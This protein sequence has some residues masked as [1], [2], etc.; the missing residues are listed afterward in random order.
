[1]KSLNA[2]YLLAGTAVR[3]IGYGAMRLAGP[4]VFGPPGIVQKQLQCCALLSTISTRRS[5]TVCNGE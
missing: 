1:V 2:Q 3:R 5:T 4:G